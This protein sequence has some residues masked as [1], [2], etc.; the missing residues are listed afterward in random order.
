MAQSL[1][2]KNA[3]KFQPNINDFEDL[4]MNSSLLLGNELS[5]GKTFQESEYNKYLKIIS[6]ESFFAF[7]SIL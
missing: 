2:N 4:N 3:I 1:F 5:Y 6:V 7:D